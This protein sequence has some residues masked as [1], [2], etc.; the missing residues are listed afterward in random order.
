MSILSKLKENLLQNLENAAKDLSED[1]LDSIIKL[2]ELG[3]RP[4]LKSIITSQ[5]FNELSLLPYVLAL[6]SDDH[7]VKTKIKQHNTKIYN[8]CTTIKNDIIYYEVMK[9][10]FVNP[11]INEHQH[12]YVTVNSLNDFLTYDH[13]TKD[14]FN[15]IGFLDSKY[16]N[17]YTNTVFKI[18]ND[19]E[20]S[21]ILHE[22]N[23]NDRKVKADIKINIFSQY[24]ER[25]RDTS[26]YYG[27]EKDFQQKDLNK[28]DI[29]F[30]IFHELAHAV[31]PKIWVDDQGSECI[32]DICGILRV[33]KNNS[34]TQD[35]ALSFINRKLNWRSGQPPLEHL[36]KDFT[37]PEF[38]KDKKTRIHS[39]Q[40]ALLILKTFIKEDYQYLKELNINE[41]YIIASRATLMATSPSNIDVFL[42]R[43]MFK[44][45]FYKELSVENFL[46]GPNLSKHL[47]SIADF[48]NTTVD[49]L[50]DN[51]MKNISN[52]P[53]NLFDLMMSH[54]AFDDQYSL[55][56]E[57][58][59]SLFSTDLLKMNLDEI[60]QERVDVNL[61]HK[62]SMKSLKNFIKNNNIKTRSLW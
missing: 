18:H 30:T 37:T 59:Y 51:I 61:D 36:S 48:R 57:K 1:A 32:S 7:E 2:K 42:E 10:Y 16:I 52:N 17:P 12:S 58:S 25:N 19:Y 8:E 56:D 35:Q 5:S 31:I 53:A 47:E 60:R 29:E 21:N 41:E 62:F 13:T 39:T 43:N 33:I 6:K 26:H 38:K 15:I 54:Y 40:F 34:F 3:V 49:V 46:K 44:Q 11:K 14:N 9:K 22:K 4:F 28:F 20:S 45:D 27:L 24:Q 50:K 55:K 23:I